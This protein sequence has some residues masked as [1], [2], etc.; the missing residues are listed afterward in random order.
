MLNVI[1]GAGAEPLRGWRS[2]H[3]VCLHFQTSP[4]AVEGIGAAGSRS[5]ETSLEVAT[6]VYRRDNAVPL[7]L[8]SMGDGE[9]GSNQDTFGKNQLQNLA[10]SWVEGSKQ[11]EHPSWLSGAGD[12][13][14]QAWSKRTSFHKVLS[15]QVHSPQGHIFF[16]PSLH[17]NKPH[18]WSVV[19]AF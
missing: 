7:R 8:S 4:P 9:T 12:G 2:Q 5:R 16:N 1:L 19:K 17:Q 3:V 18:P 10:V 6:V 13:M 11:E 14:S 15:R